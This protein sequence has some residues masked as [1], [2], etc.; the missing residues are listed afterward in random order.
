M[1]K[2]EQLIYTHCTA[3]PKNEFTLNNILYEAPQLFV[4]LDEETLNPKAI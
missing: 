4:L 3:I 1:W 2:P